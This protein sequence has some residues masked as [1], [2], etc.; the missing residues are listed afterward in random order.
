VGTLRRGG[1]GGSPPRE[2]RAK[3]A[4]AK[5]REVGGKDPPG[6]RISNS[7]PAKRAGTLLLETG[8]HRPWGV[9]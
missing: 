8:A 2:E 9:A 5:E 1:R 3:R 4:A 6:L 7:L